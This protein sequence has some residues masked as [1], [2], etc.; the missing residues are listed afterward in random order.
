[1]SKLNKRIVVLTCF[2]ISCFS[3]AQ[4]PTQKEIDIYVKQLENVT[5]ELCDVVT[6]QYKKNK[7]E[8]QRKAGKIYLNCSE[9]ADIPQCVKS[10]LDKYLIQL[11]LARSNR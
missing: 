8:C 11:E 6:K 10:G 3:Q 1:M 9:D 4:Q 5:N 7:S 2:W